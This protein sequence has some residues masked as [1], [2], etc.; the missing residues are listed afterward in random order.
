[1][2]MRQIPLLAS[3]ALCLQVSCAAIAQEKISDGTV[4]IGVMNDMSG[5]YSDVTGRAS[6]IA[7]TMAAEDFMAKEKPKF[8]VEVLSTDHQNKPDIASAKAREWFDRDK[9]DAIVDLPTSS[10]AIAVVKVASQK[11]KIT[12]VSGGGTSSLTNEECTETNI[13]WTYDT[14]A[15]ASGSAKALVKLGGDSWYF[16]VAD[17]N[18]G[19]NMEKD[20]T[21][22]I[23]SAGGKVLGSVRHPFPASDFSS[24]MLSAQQSKAKVIGLANAGSDTQNAIKSAQEYRLTEKQIVA[25][26]LMFINDVHSLGLKTTQGMY[27]TDGFYWDL[28]DETRA[29]SRR[30]FERHKA[31]PNMIQA[32]LYSAIMHYLKAVKATGTDEAKVVMAK[33]KATPVND[34]FAKNGRIRADGRMVHDMYLMQVKKPEESKSPWD[35]YHV[36][37]VIPGND[38][39]QSM[40]NGTCPLVKK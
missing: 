8:K 7:A 20:A 18:F 34:F 19:T 26:L 11:N 21:N 30:F 25:P 27:L 12:L 23:K 3:V 40:E 15:L 33:M 17:Y 10:A 14:Y 1:M 38:A 28:N 32:G 35:Y 5:L 2:R 29:W 31:M 16:L 24:Y 22:A 39:F 13:Q 4:K 9:V 37:Q 6:V 36:K